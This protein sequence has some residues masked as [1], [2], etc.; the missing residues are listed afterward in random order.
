MWSLF[1]GGAGGNNGIGYAIIARA[2]QDLGRTEEG[3]NNRGSLVREALRGTGHTENAPW[4][5]GIGTNWT[6][7]AARPLLG[8]NLVQTTASTAQMQ[9][10]Y[11]RAG[12]YSAF[13]GDVSRARVG[14]A[15]FFARNGGG[16]VAYVTSNDG[17][18]LGL[19]EGNVSVGGGNND[20]R[21]VDGVREGIFSIAE[22]QQRNITGFGHNDERFNTMMAS[23][24]L[25]GLQV[26]SASPASLGGFSSSAVP[27]NSYSDPARYMG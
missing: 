26:A 14:D 19:I 11:R 25:G 20:G 2:R 8:C 22:L 3:G 6:N 18:R 24:S 7:D 27:D 21:G 17:G 9:E 23:R 12:A 15:V 5:A 13:N 16:H 4:C 1:G 10:D